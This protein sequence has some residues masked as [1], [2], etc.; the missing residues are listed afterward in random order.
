MIITEESK[1]GFFTA[2]VRDG[3][4]VKWK[5][6]LDWDDKNPGLRVEYFLEG[7]KILY[8]RIEKKWWWK[9]IGNHIEDELQ[10]FVKQG[11]K[12]ASQIRNDRAEAAQMAQEAKI[13][14][15]DE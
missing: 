8:H 14:F 2:A 9:L 1:Y 3:E 6:Q 7:E 15:K 4:Y 13:F 5:G 11:M 10:E 12:K